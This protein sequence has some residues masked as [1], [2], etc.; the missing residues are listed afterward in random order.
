[1]DAARINQLCQLLK[2]FHQQHHHVYVPPYPAH[3]PL[4]ELTAYARQHKAALPAEMISCLHELDFDWQADNAATRWFYNYY[5]LKQFYEVHGHTDLPFHHAEDPR[6]GAWVNRQ[7]KQKDKLTDQQIA[8]LGQLN[9]TW[10]TEDA[11]YLKRWETMYDKLKAFHGRHHHSM[12]PSS[13]VDNALA[14]WVARQRKGKE[15]LSPEQI[16]KLDQL[17]FVFDI[18]K[19]RALSWEYRYNQLLLFKKEHGHTNVPSQHTNKK[20]YNWVRTQRISKDTLSKDRLKQLKD[21]HFEFSTTKQ[22]KRDQQWLENFREVEK[23]Y[24][25]NGHL[26]LPDRRLY[27]WIYKQ[28]LRWP[29]EEYRRVMLR[30][31]GLNKLK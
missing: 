31:I 27:Q 17:G 22:S 20:L 28:Q 19:Q 3:K 21:I 9:F 5:L 10:Q 29:K 1:M 13:Y 24:K 4:Y 18:Q 2:A 8:L 26:N 15:K 12:V 14:Q 16:V 7:K 11:N 23:F 30:G 6:L 25:A